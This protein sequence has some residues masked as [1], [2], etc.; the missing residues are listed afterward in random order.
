MAG[1]I[2]EYAPVDKAKALVSEGL[3]KLHVE[4]VRAHITNALHHAAETGHEKLAPFLA[5][6]LARLHTPGDA[7]SPWS[8]LGEVLDKMHSVGDQGKKQADALEAALLWRPP[9]GASSAEDRL[10][11]LTA[12]LR[13]LDAE[14]MKAMVKAVLAHAMADA[15]GAKETLKEM[16]DMASTSEGQH[17][18][19][20][21]AHAL[22]LSSKDNLKVIFFLQGMYCVVELHI[23][24]FPH[25]V[26]RAFF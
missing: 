23:R 9:H 26:P 22:V 21:Q 8:M 1:K 7:E 25:K 20:A 11:A 17:L 6:V 16:T 15:A 5:M 2:V 3:A 4:E 18:L 24:F 14:T 12:S 13:A 19:A 10:E